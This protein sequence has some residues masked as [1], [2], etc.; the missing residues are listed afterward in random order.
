MSSQI[1]V[2]LLEWDCMLI[3]RKD[4]DGQ[5]AIMNSCHLGMSKPFEVS[6]RPWGSSMADKNLRGERAMAGL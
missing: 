3:G 6:R 1:C 5:H 2:S 4:M